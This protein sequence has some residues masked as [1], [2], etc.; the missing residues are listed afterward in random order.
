MLKFSLG[1]REFG[2][3]AIVPDI[4]RMKAEEGKDKL[5]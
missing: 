1:I 3:F 4:S 5:T 2:G